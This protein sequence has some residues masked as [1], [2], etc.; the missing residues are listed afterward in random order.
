MEEL[1]IVLGAIVSLLTIVGL[2]TGFFKKA[3]TWL[4][5]VITSTSAAS[6]IPKRTLVAVPTQHP[7]PFS[8]HMGRSGDKPS[9]QI[10]GDVIVTNISEQNLLLT[11]VRLKKLRARGHVIVQGFDSNLHGEFYIPP[12]LST[13]ARFDFWIK[14][15]AKRE[16]QVL[17]VALQS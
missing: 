10:V 16:G 14:P 6:S 12:G 9:M 11:G 17:G 1:G 7:V 13:T 2:V 5:R 4:L 15:P 3:Y 8:W